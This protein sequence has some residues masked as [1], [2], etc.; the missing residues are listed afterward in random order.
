M[1]INGK[2]IILTGASSGIGLDLLKKLTRFDCKILAVAR[3]IEKVDFEHPNVTKY[4][5]D[6][7][8]PK[9][10][11]G[12]FDHALS[13]WG[14]ID[15]YIANAGF[16]YYEEIESPDWEHIEKIYKTNV[17]SSFYAAEKMKA[18]NQ[19]RPF[20]MVVTASAMSF[21]S[22]PGYSLYSSTKAAI[23][24]FAAAYR[25]ELEKEQ[26][27]QLV[28]P[29][30]TRTSFFKEAGSGT[31]VPWP[32]QEP[33]KVSDAIIRGIEKDKNSIFPS[34]LFNSI[35]IMNGYVHFLY[36]VIAWMEAKKLYKWNA[37][38]K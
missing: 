36:P 26:K 27:L 11:D 18:I 37:G 21:L 13:Q 38:K 23:R 2:N 12:L 30:A 34:A 28:Y 31:P 1:D 20:R 29:I 25:Y 16:A 24:G 5:C 14:H 8:D 9:K 3:T 4:P 10:L 19:G 33:E 15:I 6:I 22:L 35:R 17:F 7:S 32:S